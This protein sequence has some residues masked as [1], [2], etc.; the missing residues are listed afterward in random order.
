M[1]PRRP[2]QAER[3]HGPFRW[4]WSTAVLLAVLL[5][6]GARS[7]SAQA[8]PTP[9]Q[10]DTIRAVSV[11]ELVFPAI[12]G[13]AVGSVGGFYAGRQLGWGG[14]DDPGLTGAVFGAAFASTLLTSVAIVGTSGGTIAPAGA[15]GP[16]AMGAMAGVGA[17]LLALSA[18]ESS[19]EALVCVVSYSLAQGIV[20]S[21]LAATNQ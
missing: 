1:L 3:V 21:L 16:S 18:T 9:A 17:A 12:A 10:S 8:L 20:A 2:A 13:S 5:P 11:S 15:W 14:G 19:S 4:T 7:I 6:L